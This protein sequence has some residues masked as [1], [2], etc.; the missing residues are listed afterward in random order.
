MKNVRMLLTGAIVMAIVGSSLAF[1]KN[2]P[3]LF[4]CVGSPIQC[5]AVSASSFDPGGGLPLP[6]SNYY[7][8]N[9]AKLNI[10][11]FAP[12]STTQGC[13]RS[14]HPAQAFAND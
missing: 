5:L 14:N 4:A 1:T 12:H 13:S 7:T 8:T 2:N 11:C 9:K 6:P 10:D 3:D